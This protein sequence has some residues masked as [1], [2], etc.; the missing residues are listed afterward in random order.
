MMKNK[1]HKRTTVLNAQL[2]PD[3]KFKVTESYKVARTNLAFSVIKQGCKKI[4]V[5]SSLAGEGKSTTAV[6]VAISLAQQVDVKVLLIDCDL[7][8]PQ[9]SRFFSLKNAPGL[10]DYLGKMSTLKDIAHR[11]ENENLT[12]ICSGTM[13]PNPSELLASEAMGNLLKT[14]EDQYD[15]IIVDTPPINVVIDALPLMKIT[16]GVVIV[17]REGSSTHPELA[18]TIEKLGRVDAKILGII[19]NGAKMESKD[20]YKYHYE[21]YE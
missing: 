5:T 20:N 2:D 14:M 6:N 8:K 4:I 13:V 11:I 19:L 16:D 12:V 21:R 15:Y 17:V 1:Q 9:V 3:M 10:T 18:R 7:R